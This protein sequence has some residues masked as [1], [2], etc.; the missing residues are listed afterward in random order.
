MTPRGRLIPVLLVLLAPRIAAQGDA[1]ERE[2]RLHL[3][4]AARRLHDTGYEPVPQSH[5]GALNTGESASFTMTL[6]A[7]AA[8][9][10]T[11][12]CDPD[13][14]ALDLALYAPNGYEVD[15][16]RSA[17]SAPIVQ[18]APRE[19]GKYRLLVVMTRCTTNPC[20]YGVAEFRKRQ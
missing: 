11:G 1:W 8:Y 4:Q 9:V 10:L 15:A 7:G 12:V 20:R 3:S 13:C 6:E 19:T 5:A 16:A 2:V 18:V 17:E 14:D